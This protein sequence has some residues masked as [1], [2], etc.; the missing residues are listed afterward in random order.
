MANGPPRAVGA[1]PACVDMPVG[2]GAAADAG[3]DTAPVLTRRAALRLSLAAGA[4][5]AVPP[6]AFAQA[7]RAPLRIVGPWEIAG[8]AP[9]SSGFVFTRL[10][11]AETLMDAHD[12]GAPLPGLAVRWRVSDDRLAWRFELRPGARFHDGTP[13]TAGAVAR[14]LRIARTPP[15]R[16]CWRRRHRAPRRRARHCASSVRGRSP[17]SRRPAAAMSSRAC[18]SPRP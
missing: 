14:C 10:Q 17:D 8:L 6:G 5:T 3:P 11:V 4:V 13:V 7:D 9:A 1:E 2:A 16:P 18:R 15:A 12:D